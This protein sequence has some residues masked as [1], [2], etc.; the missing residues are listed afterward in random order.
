MANY[1]A[2][3][4]GGRFLQVYNGRAVGNPAGTTGF[5]PNAIQLLSANPHRYARQP[6]Q[7][8]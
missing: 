5:E 4:A 2:I 3:G 6:G 1:S 7:V 8:Y